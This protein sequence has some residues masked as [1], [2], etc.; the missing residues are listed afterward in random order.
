MFEAERD[1]YVIAVGIDTISRF[2]PTYH[3]TT[4]VEQVLDA[5]G[6]D[7]SDGYLLD[8]C[9]MV[10]FVDGEV[11]DLTQNL[12]NQYPHLQAVTE[13]FATNGIN[14]WRDGA[15]FHPAEP[16]RTKIIDFATKDAYYEGELELIM[17]E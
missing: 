17:A 9:Y 3:G 10:D 14:H 16:V 6:Q 12:V 7:I 15:V 5:A 8:C 1:A 4:E 11:A 2:V 13:A